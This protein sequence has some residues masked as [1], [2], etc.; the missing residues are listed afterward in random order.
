MRTK[1]PNTRRNTLRTKHRANQTNRARRGIPISRRGVA[2]V[3]A[4][5]FLI[6]FGS[7]VAAMAVASTGNIRTAN[8]H[9]HVMR[10]MSAA[11]TGLAVAEHRLNEASSRFVL[12]ESDI[13]ANVAWVFGLVIALR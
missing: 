2:S 10:A 3:L 4:M 13:D 1:R 6:I 7:L 12:A 5:M 9:L 8:M 11:E